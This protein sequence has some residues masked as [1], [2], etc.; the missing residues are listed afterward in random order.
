MLSPS[1][2]STSTANTPELLSPLEKHEA[3]QDEQRGDAS[4]SETASEGE[5]RR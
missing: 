5:S 4:E 3:T 2:Q 1:F